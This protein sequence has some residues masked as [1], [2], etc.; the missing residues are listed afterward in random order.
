[1]SQLSE[2]PSSVITIP[3][4]AENEWRFS[5]QFAATQPNLVARVALGVGVLALM[6]VAANAA[7]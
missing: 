2:S 5:Y 6:I 7:W 3:A 4:S 1:V